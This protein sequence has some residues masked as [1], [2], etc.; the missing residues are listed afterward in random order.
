MK[1]G[2]IGAGNMGSILAKGAIEKY[3][4]PNVFVC[5]KSS[6]KLGGFDVGQV[7]Q[8]INNLIEKVDVMVLCVKPQG[9]NELVQEIEKD[10]SEKFVVS[11]MAGITIK[12]ITNALKT[13]REHGE[14]QKLFIF[15]V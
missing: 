15:R 6:E 14:V 7:C 12:K 8:D 4:V 2:I 10:T 9:F 11:I 5:D 3:G 13:D 1:I